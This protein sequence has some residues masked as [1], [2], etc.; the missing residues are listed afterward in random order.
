MIKEER[1]KEFQAYPSLWETQQHS[2]T[3]SSWSQ[4]PQR[5]W[6]WEQTS[7]CRTQSL[8]FR[9]IYLWPSSPCQ[10][11]PSSRKRTDTG[12]AERKE[13][14]PNI[15]STAACQGKTNTVKTNWASRTL[16]IFIMLVF[17]WCWFRTCSSMYY[18]YYILKVWDM[19]TRFWC[20][21]KYKRCA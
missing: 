20:Q 4:W 6:Y 15:S 19:Q 3:I 21:S 14:T 2:D 17:V 1:K 16:S 7:E 18:Y 10:S 5:R 9:C 12:T 8:D 13:P 11:K